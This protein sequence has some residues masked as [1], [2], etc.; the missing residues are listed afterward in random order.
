MV[1]GAQTPPK[2]VNAIKSPQRRLR[3]HR[4]NLTDSLLESG[5]IPMMVWHGEH[6]QGKNK[7]GKLHGPP[8]QQGAG[9]YYHPKVHKGT[10]STH[11][12]NN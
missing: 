3:R 2:A 8:R 5:P 4:T 1:K 10:F 7:W 6:S 9:E 11:G 12:T